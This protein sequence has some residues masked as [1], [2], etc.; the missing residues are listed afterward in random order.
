MR[1]QTS[2]QLFIVSMLAVF[3]FYGIDCKKNPISPPPPPTQDAGVKI[4][5]GIQPVVSPDGQ[6]IAFSRYGSIITCD[7]SGKQERKLTSGAN[8]ILP[9]FSPDGQKVGF[10]RPL[11]SKNGQI[12]SVTLADSQVVKLSGSYYLSLSFLQTPSFTREPIWDWSPRGDN[13]AF[14]QEDA[15]ND[16][17]LRIMHANGDGLLIGNYEIRNTSIPGD[18]YAPGFSWAPDGL[19]L[20]CISNSI[21][22]TGHVGIITVG[23]DSIKQFTNYSGEL[24]PI[25]MPDGKSIFFQMIGWANAILKDVTTG[26]EE[27]FPTAPKMDSPK[28]S[29]NMR[30]VVSAWN[31]PKEEDNLGVYVS[32]LQI[33]DFSSKTSRTLTTY[34]DEFLSQTENYFFEWDRTSQYVYFERYQSIWKIKI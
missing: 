34:G 26:A 20:A 31:V 22:G 6:W 9:R 7:T 8:D 33:F 15:G 13:I 18:T 29:P 11:D 5:D 12:Y 10:V 2:E 32:L 3:T 16:V 28:I 14:L 24:F 25:W 4:T 1:R 27:K 17:F 23:V 30:Y 19:H 21:P